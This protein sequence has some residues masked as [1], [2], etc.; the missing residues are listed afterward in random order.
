MS[1]T[2]KGSYDLGYTVRKPKER[3]FWDHKKIFSNQ[4]KNDKIFSK[5]ITNKQKDPE[6][7]SGLVIEIF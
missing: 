5:K 3:E 1:L 2:E 7:F 6:I 4:K